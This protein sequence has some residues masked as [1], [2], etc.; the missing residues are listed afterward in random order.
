[1]HAG[2]TPWRL[3]FSSHAELGSGL[4]RSL[5]TEHCCRIVAVADPRRAAR[6]A[7]Q[8]DLGLSAPALYAD[9][10]ATLRS[11]AAD[12]LLVNTPSEPHCAQARAALERGLHVLVAK[13]ITNSFRD[14]ARLVRLA[15][16]RRLKLAVEQQIRFNR[17]CRAVRDFVASG[18]LGR[19]EPVHSPDSKPRR[20]ARNLASLEQPAL[21]EMSCHQFDALLAILPR[22]ARE[23]RRRR[24]PS[25]LVR[26]PG[27]C[28]MNALI[29]LSGGVHVLYHGGFSAQ[30]DRLARDRAHPWRSVGRLASARRLR[31]GAR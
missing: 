5:A 20:R 28:M 25:Q 27:P 13:P 6:K 16:A 21:L 1:M 2:G 19:I 4:A 10:D 14:A 31:R 7:A 8:A 26:V 9:C 29:R 30:A 12:V 23:D 17:D 18:A 22:A 11:V 24:R 3:A 15:R